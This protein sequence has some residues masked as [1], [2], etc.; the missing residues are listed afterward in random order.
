MAHAHDSG[1]DGG[2]E[3][4]PSGKRLVGSHH[5][6]DAPISGRPLQKVARTLA[7]AA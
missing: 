3:T 4:G 2:V 1:L 6:F 7:D 5:E